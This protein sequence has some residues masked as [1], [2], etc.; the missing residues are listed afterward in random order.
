MFLVIDTLFIYRILI[1]FLSTDID[2]WVADPKT[3]K[4]YLILE[5][6]TLNHDI[7]QKTC[8]KYNGHLPEPKNEHDNLFLNSLG[9]ETF[10]LGIN[11][12]RVDGQWVFDSDG[13]IVT[14]DSWFVDVKRN[15]NCAFMARNY[16]SHRPQDWDKIPCTSTAYDAL[17]KALICQKHT[18]EGII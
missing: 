9:T 8:K 12:K 16:Y 4:K 7:N 13:S 15:G 18:G 5:T 11:D 2:D 1:C 17:P 10:L 14:W 3:G 6:P